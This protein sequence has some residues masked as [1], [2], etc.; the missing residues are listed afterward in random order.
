ML[1]TP[2][3]KKAHILCFQA[4]KNQTDQGGLPYVFHPLHLAEQMDTE[5]EI[6]VALLHD[7]IEDTSCTIETIR[8]EGFSPAVC[9][10]LSAMTRQPGMPYMDYIWAL[11][12]NALA[13]KVKLA[14]LNHNMDLSRLKQVSPN[15]LRRL[16]KYRIAHALLQETSYDEVQHLYCQRLPLNEQNTCFFIIYYDKKN[17]IQTDQVLKCI[18]HISDSDDNCY[19]YELL[20]EAINQLRDALRAAKPE[21][22]RTLSLPELLS[23]YFAEHPAPM[24]ASLMDTLAIPYRERQHSSA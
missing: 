14:D 3:T 19:S 11:R 23:D 8:E 7:V 13:R 16:Q 5:E 6:C 18:I 9:E 10:A 15:G 1:Y 22:A 20:P 17:Q 24:A 12:P 4:H 2:M 21:R